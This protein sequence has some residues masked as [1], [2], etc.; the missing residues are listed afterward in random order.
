MLRN[1][2]WPSVT[3]VSCPSTVTQLRVHLRRLRLLLDC[4][5]L[6]WHGWAQNKTQNINPHGQILHEVCLS[7][8]VSFRKSREGATVIPTIPISYE[9]VSTSKVCRRCSSQHQ[10]LP[11]HPN[12]NTR[13]SHKCDIPS[14]FRELS[15][16]ESTISV[17]VEELQKRLRVKTK[18]TNTEIQNQA[19]VRLIYPPTKRFQ[20]AWLCGVTKRRRSKCTRNTVQSKPTIK[21]KQ[22]HKNKGATR[23]HR[24]DFCPAAHQ[25]P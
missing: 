15:G 5:H 21:N 11:P 6:A 22:T 1:W 13:C 2:R 20:N 25:C 10:S 14:A 19:D 18:N 16:I 23:R 3:F 9:N 24:L 12:P 17:V 4:I 7:H 8:A